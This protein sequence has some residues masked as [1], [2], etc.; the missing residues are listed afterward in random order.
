MFTSLTTSRLRKIS[1]FVGR[2]LDRH[3][4]LKVATHVW[5]CKPR[6]NLV[7]CVLSVLAAMYT[8]SDVREKIPVWTHQCENLNH[9]RVNSECVHYSLLL[10]FKH[11]HPRTS[12]V[13]KPD[14]SYSKLQISHN[15]PLQHEVGDSRF[16]QD[17]YAYLPNY[18]TSHCRK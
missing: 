14:P 5:R 10:F 3:V 17:V 8:F 15:K 12:E 11:V 6:Q 9:H 16:L 4:R 7:C 18:M 13:V 1:P 2:S